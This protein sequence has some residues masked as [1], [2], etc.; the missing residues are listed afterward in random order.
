MADRKNR[1]KADVSHDRHYDLGLMQVDLHHVGNEYQESAISVRFDS[2]RLS[3]VEPEYGQFGPEPS[4]A[5][6]IIA[7]VKHSLRER[8]MTVLDKKKGD[9]DG[10]AASGGS[11][12]A[13]HRL[14]TEEFS[15]Y[16]PGGD[17]T[18]I[19]AAKGYY[20]DHM[21]NADAMIDVA[22]DM[23]DKLGRQLRTARTSDAFEERLNAI[24]RAVDFEQKPLDEAL[25]PPRHA[26]TRRETV[27]TPETKLVDAVSA[28]LPMKLVAGEERT[29]AISAIVKGVLCS[30][31]ACWI[32]E[33]IQDRGGKD[34]PLARKVHEALATADARYHKITA[35]VMPFLVG[36]ICD[37]V[38]ADYD[39]RMGKSGHGA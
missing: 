29:L 19:R 36:E 21:F 16:K 13:T 35:T 28:K 38:Y 37:A 25:T 22:G 18:R 7:L 24:H 15:T 11:H 10:P 26:N 30:G 4:A 17:G 34:D 33:G 3:L 14:A 39:K 27:Q 20:E 9:H 32:K 31:E 23:L 2:D 5:D 6:K 12:G 1:H 8:G